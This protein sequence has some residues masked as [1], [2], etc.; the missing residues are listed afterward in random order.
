MVPHVLKARELVSFLVRLFLALISVGLLLV[1]LFDLRF[2]LTQP[3]MIEEFVKELPTWLVV[4]GSA[5]GCVSSNSFRYE[6]CYSI[7]LDIISEI[8][9]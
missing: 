3:L 8:G 6:Q 5:K 9:P 1:I 4:V 2:I 7:N